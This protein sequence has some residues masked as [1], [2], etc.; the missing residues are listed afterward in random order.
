MTNHELDQPARL[1]GL[2]PTATPDECLLIAP[3]STLGRAPS[4]D[5]VVAGRIVSRV[6]ARIERDGPR[7]LLI[8][9][10][11]ANGTFIN[12]NRIS[13]PHLLAHNDAI[14]LGTALAVLRFLDPDPTYVPVAR[15][16]FDEHTLRFMLNQR[17]LAVSQAQMRLLT[18]L[19]RHVGTLCTRE[20]CAEAIWGRDYDP[21]LDAAA[22]DRAI[23]NLRAALRDADPSADFIQTRRG[24]GYVLE[25]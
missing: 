21:G 3:V 20:Q 16:Q 1:I 13:Q 4:C 8:D 12:G 19:Y 2:D 5:L 18:F 22:L 24:V 14:G 10:G 15:L 9:V 17:P 25:L 11:S 6:H 7:Y 23:A